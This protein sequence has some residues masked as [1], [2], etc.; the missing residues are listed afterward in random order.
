MRRNLAPPGEHGGARLPRI[1]SLARGQTA[2]ICDPHAREHETVGAVLT[3]CRGGAHG[4]E[5]AR[6]RASEASI[7]DRTTRRSRADGTG[8]NVGVDAGPHR[9]HTRTVPN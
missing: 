9:G 7:A 6:D 4:P 2:W 8:V 1:R 5:P 3:R